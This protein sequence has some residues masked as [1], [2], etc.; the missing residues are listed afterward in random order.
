MNGAVSLLE[1]PEN[2]DSVLL[3]LLLDLDNVDTLDIED[4]DPNLDP[5]DLLVRPVFDDC[6]D[7]TVFLEFDVRSDLEEMPDT[8]ERSDLDDSSEMEDTLDLEVI[9][10]T[11]VVDLFCSGSGCGWMFI[12][13]ERERCTSISNWQPSFQKSVLIT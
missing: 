2:E 3:P 10:E 8:T 12:T 11:A 13:L 9:T 7:F 1:L 4:S 5:V 6:P